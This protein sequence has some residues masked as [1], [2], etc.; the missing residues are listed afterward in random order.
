MVFMISNDAMLWSVLQCAESK[1]TEFLFYTL[2]SY[3]SIKK[4]IVVKLLIIIFVA[5]FKRNSGLIITFNI[6]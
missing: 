3:I 4:S 2:L 5:E 1:S 6:Y